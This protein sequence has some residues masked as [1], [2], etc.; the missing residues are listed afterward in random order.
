VAT[1][2]Y[3]LVAL[4]AVALLPP[5]RLARSASPLADAM[6]VGAPRLAGALGAVALF[7]TANTALVASLS[8]SRLLFGIARHGD[9]PRPFT[10]LLAGRRTPAW[11][12]GAVLAG[13]LALVPFGRVELLGSVSSL[14]ALAAFVLV[15]V[16]LIVLRFRH[17]R[18]ERPFRVPLTLGRVSLPAIA[19]GLLALVLAARFEPAAYVIFGGV[20]LL[21]VVAVAVARGSRAGSS[22]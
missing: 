17:P 2:L 9:A 4:A 12:L 1:V 21:G 3:V 16:S 15:N 8:A 14:A 11:A 6:R 19:A 20:M 22:D 7:A 10:R 13:A 18:M 5:E